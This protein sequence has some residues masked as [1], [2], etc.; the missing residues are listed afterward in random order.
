MSD[1]N[2]VILVGR[3]V[4]DAE[5]KYTNTGTALSVFSI[6]ANEYYKSD[7]EKKEIVSYFEITMWGKRAESLSKYLLKGNQIC[8]VGRLKQDRWTQDGANRS[9]IKIVCEDIQLLG[10]KN[11]KNEDVKQPEEQVPEVFEDDIPF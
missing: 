2:K 11:K 1:V 6:A 5:L 3:L 7:N 4:R 8:V 10:S 9:K